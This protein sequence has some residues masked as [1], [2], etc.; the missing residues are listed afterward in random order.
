MPASLR[1]R[2]L[3]QG[4]LLVEGVFGGDA[5]ASAL[6]SVAGVPEWI[7]RRSNNRNIQRAQPL[8]SC[9]VIE[10]SSWIRSFY[11]NPA[12]DRI[13][14]EVFGDV[15]VPTPRMSSDLQLTALMIDP[16]DRWWATGLH[17][18][19]RDFLEGLDVAE[20]RSRTGDLRLFNQINIAL[21]PDDCLWAVPGSHTRDDTDAEAGM[22]AGRTRYAGLVR[23]KATTHPAVQYRAELTDALAACGAVNLRLAP[24][25]FLLYRSNIL[26]CGI[27]EPGVARMT[28]HDGVYSAQWH[29]Y[30]LS[31]R[32]SAVRNVV[33]PPG[34]RALGAE[35][36]Q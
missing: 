27:Y 22:V 10:D 9:P 21:L 23:D 3:E 24:G 15:I 17:R 18:D 25:D 2:Y 28:L 7:R 16:L 5:V 20:W 11:D 36:R 8:Q 34:F 19:Y 35:T 30:A 6:R 29:D 31:V 1:K 14:D 4:Y 12:L 32:N 26:H 33:P 13:L